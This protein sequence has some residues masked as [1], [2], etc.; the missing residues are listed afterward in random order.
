MHGPRRAPG[1]AARASSFNRPYGG[2]KMSS[3]RQQTR[4]SKQD[5]AAQPVVQVASG[6]DQKP[7]AF[8]G[9][10][11]EGLEIA[12]AVRARIADTARVTMWNEGFFSPGG[13]IIEKLVNSLGQFDFAILVLRPEDLVR[14]RGEELLAARDNVIFE[15]GLF[16]AHLGRQRTFMLVQA[17]TRLPS[18]LAGVQVV[19]YRDD[20]Q[21]NA[22]F[23]QAMEAVSPACDYIR[24][25]IHDLGIAEHRTAA[26]LAQ[27][28][29]RQNRMESRIDALQV[30]VKGIVTKFE[31]EKLQ[32]L[33]EKGPFLVRYHEDM[34]FELKRLDAIRYVKPTHSEGLNAVRRLHRGSDA[35]F[36]LKQYVEVTA[37]GREYVRLR[38]ELGVSSP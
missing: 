34:Y 25:I 36:D 27:V 9:S 2:E 19:T 4:R 23:N 16:M 3:N 12:R 28:T 18:D 32:G 7:T 14:K 38:E 30:V 24:G 29:Q 5:Q 15:L 13:T 31:L 6:N 10:S 33:L 8:I 21:T 22:G 26:Q 37:D 17:T 11:S 35:D 1:A 20:A